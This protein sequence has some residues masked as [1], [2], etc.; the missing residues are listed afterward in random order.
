[1]YNEE[2]KYTL[3]RNTHWAEDF[4]KNEKYK[5]CNDNESAALQIIHHVN[6]YII[7]YYVIISIY[8]YISEYNLQLTSYLF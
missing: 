8:D 3:K 2:K 6:R 5:D 7:N 4:E 1:M